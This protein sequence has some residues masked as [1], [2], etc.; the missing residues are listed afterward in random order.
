LTVA[1]AAQF[2]FTLRITLLLRISTRDSRL[3][4]ND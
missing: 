4:T 3:T 2:V 1:G